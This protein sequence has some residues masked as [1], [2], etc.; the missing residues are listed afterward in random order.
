[1]R[2]RI[3][4]NQELGERLA[5]LRPVLRGQVVAT[6][7]EAHAAEVDLAELLAARR[8]LV[9]LGTLINQSLRASRGSLP[10]AAAVQEAADIII[11]LTKK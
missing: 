7:L 1:M 2:I 4:I 11:A 6:V 10:D 3:R 9:R 5:T 8:E